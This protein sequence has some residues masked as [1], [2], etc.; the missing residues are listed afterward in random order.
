MTNNNEVIA[1]KVW[2][3]TNTRRIYAVIEN[4]T[5]SCNLDVF[6]PLQSIRSSLLK[7]FF[8]ENTA[9]GIISV[10]W[11]WPGTGRTTISMDYLENHGKLVDMSNNSMTDYV[12]LAPN[13]FA[14]APMGFDSTA[15]APEDAQ[16][17]NSTPS[18]NQTDIAARYDLISPAAIHELAMLRDEGAKKYGEHNHESISVNSHI[19]HA[20]AHLYNYVEEGNHDELVHAFCRVMFAIEVDI[21]NTEEAFEHGA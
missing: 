19:N 13:K 10:G 16:S 14:D 15:I 9:D 6:K 18:L 1:S 2:V 12:S 7:D 5:Y 17:V 8:T 21:A 3:D 4:K 20:I 11:Q